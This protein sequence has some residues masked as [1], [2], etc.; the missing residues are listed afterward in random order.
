MTTEIAM[1]EMTVAVTT[2]TSTMLMQQLYDYKLC[3]FRFKGNIMWLSR[4]HLTTIN[5]LLTNIHVCWNMD[6][7]SLNPS[8]KMKDVIAF[9]ELKWNWMLLT[10]NPNFTMEIYTLFPNKPWDFQRVAMMIDVSVLDICNNS[11][12]REYAHIEKPEDLNFENMDRSAMYGF[13]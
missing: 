1:D 7:I 10:H 3:N 6:A 12:C 2:I 5:V 4:H 11:Q 8:I 13:D 9:P